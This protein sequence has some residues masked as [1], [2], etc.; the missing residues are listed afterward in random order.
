M[1]RLA[2][3]CLALA[4]VAAPAAA[5]AGD[6]AGSQLKRLAGRHRAEATSLPAGHMC[7]KCAAK[8]PKRVPAD[9]PG[10][11]QGVGPDGTCV[12][13]QIAAQLPPGAVIVSEGPATYA[14][15][16]SGYAPAGGE[17]PG[18]ASVGGYDPATPAGEPAPIGVMRTEYSPAAG[19]TGSTGI[20]PL[21]GNRGVGPYAGFG[22]GYGEA[23]GHA[24]VGG[25]QGGYMPGSLPTS[26]V[27]P[28]QGRRPNVIA[29]L[30]GLPTLHRP[31][32]FA[33]KRRREA[34][35]QVSY[36]NMGGAPDALPASMVYGPR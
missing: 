10:M 5:R 36:G 25:P 22:A 20:D 31:G 4:M 15:G 13:C 9:G 2:Q 35:A 30:L 7:A 29:H 32:Y 23:P 12:S 26:M 19:Y 6:P 24:T 21:H 16:A 17:A 11:P 8:L 28:P 3:V 27:N 18:F 34:H 1:R 14:P 33:E